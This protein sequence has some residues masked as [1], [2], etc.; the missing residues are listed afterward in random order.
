MKRIATAVVIVAVAA[1][2]FAAGRAQWKYPW[3]RDRRSEYLNTP[4]RTVQ[5]DVL[6]YRNAI[7]GEPFALGDAD[8]VQMVATPGDKFLRVAV[9]VRAPDAGQVGPFDGSAEARSRA[10]SIFVKA[11]LP[12]VKARF[13]DTGPNGETLVAPV[14]Q[15]GK[16]VFCFSRGSYIWNTEAPK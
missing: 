2:A 3:V 12:E 8:V 15:S 4:V 6:C 13:C 11:L 10:A 16:Q 14:F 1:G 7:V 9:T 5:L